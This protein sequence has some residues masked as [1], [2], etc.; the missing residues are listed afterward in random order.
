MKCQKYFQFENSR[1]LNDRKNIKYKT[2]FDLSGKRYF[3]FFLLE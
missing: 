1:F 3:F 2:I